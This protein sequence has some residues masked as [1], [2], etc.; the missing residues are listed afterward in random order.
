ME[1]SRPAPEHAEA[2][3]L[4][5]ALLDLEGEDRARPLLDLLAGCR[6]KE[7]AGR[8]LVG[9]LAAT[10]QLA[11]GAVVAWADETGR[12]PHDILA[13][14]LGQLQ[15]GTSAED[16]D[17]AERVPFGKR[18]ATLYVWD[19]IRAFLDGTS[20]AAERAAKA[21]DHALCPPGVDEGILLDRC[22]TT[23]F[24]AI[25]IAAEAVVGYCDLAGRDPYDFVD[26][27]EMHALHCA[28]LDETDLD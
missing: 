6:D 17:D 20:E 26:E 14:R 13:D 10:A 16:Q 27:Q 1:E 7:E 5:T 24:S 3:A 21:T 25:A 8:R 9:L 4:V 28:G 22:F 2:V 18:Q 15:A 11:L 23:V 19:T 12:D